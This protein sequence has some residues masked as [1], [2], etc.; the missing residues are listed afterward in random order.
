MIKIENLLQRCFR[1]IMKMNVNFDGYFD[2][3]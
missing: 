2:M 1:N 3:I